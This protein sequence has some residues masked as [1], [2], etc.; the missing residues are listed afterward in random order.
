MTPAER[1][2]LVAMAEGLIAT[3][4]LLKYP[5]GLERHEFRRYVDQ[6][7]GKLAEARLALRQGEADDLGDD[8]KADI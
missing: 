8:C 5:E 1:Q 6:A 7:I 4:R 3:L 2:A